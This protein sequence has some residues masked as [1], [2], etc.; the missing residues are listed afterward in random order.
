M[1]IFDLALILRKIERARAKLES[2]QPG[3]TQ[4]RRQKREE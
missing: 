1:L 3:C 2:I 4:P